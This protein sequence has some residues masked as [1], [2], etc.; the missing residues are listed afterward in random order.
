MYRAVAAKVKGFAAQDLASTPWD[1]ATTNWVAPAVF[2]SL[3][4]A[5]AAKVQAFSAHPRLGVLLGPA[6][7]PRLGV[8]LGPARGPRLGVQLGPARGLQLDVQLGPARG[9]QLGV[10]YMS[11]VRDIIKVDVAFDGDATVCAAAE[12]CYTC[13]EGDTSTVGM[14]LISAACSLLQRS[15]APASSTTRAWSACS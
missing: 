14:Q 5:A 6:R 7:V 1:M 8:R 3:C 2:D 13:F 4:R 11:R 15:G 9:L 10:S 12:V